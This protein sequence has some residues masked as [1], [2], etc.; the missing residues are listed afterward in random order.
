[1]TEEIKKEGNLDDNIQKEG[2]LKSFIIHVALFLTISII[3]GLIKTYIF[4][5]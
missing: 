5:N 1:M 4:F 3:I 2:D